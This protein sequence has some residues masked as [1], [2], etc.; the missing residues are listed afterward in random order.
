MLHKIPQEW[1]QRNAAPTV[2]GWRMEQG[3]Q[4]EQD[5][6]R[7]HFSLS[8]VLKHFMH[9]HEDRWYFCLEKPPLIS[10]IG[11]I[12]SEERLIS[13]NDRADVRVSF[14]ASCCNQE[15]KCA[16]SC[17]KCRPEPCLTLEPIPQQPRM[18]NNWDGFNYTWLPLWHSQKTLI[19]TRHLKQ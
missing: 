5:T 1:K 16:Y 3:Y 2:E 19:N 13:V 18:P 17:V 12:F 4:D 14:P 8:T 7:A 11:L 15:I 9:K 6:L 10:A